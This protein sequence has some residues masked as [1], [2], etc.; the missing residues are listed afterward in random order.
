M[1]RTYVVLTLCAALVATVCAAGLWLYNRGTDNARTDQL[2][3]TLNN[4]QTFN[5][6]AGADAGC[7]FIERLS[8]GCVATD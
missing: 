6:G 3:R 7:G 8:E 5:E 4:A 2:E 1:I